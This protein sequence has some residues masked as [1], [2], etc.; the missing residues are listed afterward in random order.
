MRVRIIFR[1]LT[2]FEFAKEA[3]PGD[4]KHN[5]GTLT[6]H[7]VSHGTGAHVHRPKLQIYGLTTSNG[8]QPEPAP[9]RQFN[10]TVTMALKRRTSPPA[11]VSVATSFLDYVPDLN[12]LSPRAKRSGDIDMG[13]VEAS[14]V[15]NEGT[16]RARDF[17]SWDWHGNAPVPVAYMGTSFRGF[18]ASEA[19]VDIDDK[20]VVGDNCFVIE[21]N[22]SATNGEWTPMV[23]GSE[24]SD[25]VSPNTV[26]VSITNFAHQR[27][28][29]LYW[30]M[31]YQW[32]F[33]AAGFEPLLDAA[34][35]EPLYAK[36]EQYLALK[37]AAQ[38]FDKTEWDHDFD[39]IVQRLGHPFPFILD[40]LEPL[41]PIAEFREPYVPTGHPPFPPGTGHD[42]RS[43]PICPFGH[44]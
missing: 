13:F 44:I 43:R 3:D 2:L 9:A 28:H 42:P 39:D 34:T 12:L 14:V 37:K 26:E 8:T 6:A 17:V 15:L 35:K 38:D 33:A 32:L 5:R 11:G 10:E 19:V 22:D 20:S 27:P 29:P 24:T 25:D 16:L 41:A 18:A 30:N 23:M 4:P 21:S 31:H 40:R 1:G 7:L 36:S